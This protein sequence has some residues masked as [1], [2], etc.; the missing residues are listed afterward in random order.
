M[1][2]FS[3]GYADQFGGAKSRKLMY[4]RF[5]ELLISIS[6]LPMVEQRNQ[7]DDFLSDWMGDEEQVDDIIVMGV[8]V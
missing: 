3:D 6:Y 1:Y 2:L 8:K 5:R 4:K 7:L